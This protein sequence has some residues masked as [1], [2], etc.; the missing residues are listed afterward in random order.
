MPGE[1]AVAV[2][3]DHFFICKYDNADDKLFTPLALAIRRMVDVGYERASAA[4]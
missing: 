2:A 3:K 1:T 4:E